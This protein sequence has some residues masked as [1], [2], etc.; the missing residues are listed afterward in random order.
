MFFF[1]FFLCEQL[2]EYRFRIKLHSRTAP[3]NNSN[4]KN[5]SLATL[6]FKLEYEL[7]LAL[8]WRLVG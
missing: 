5:E 7:E 3:M 4:K 8:W 6:G 1:C 2:L